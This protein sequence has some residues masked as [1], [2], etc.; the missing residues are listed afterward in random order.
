MLASRSGKS[1]DRVTVGTYNLLE[2]GLA[3]GAIPWVMVVPSALTNEASNFEEVR[4]F[5]TKEYVV[6]WHKNQAVGDYRRFRKL[7]GEHIPTDPVQAEQLLDGLRAEFILNPDSGLAEEDSVLVNGKKCTTLR[8]ILRKT[9]RAREN[10][11][12]RPKLAASEPQPSGSQ[13]AEFQSR[14]LAERIFT[15]IHLSNTEVFAW[16]KR[17]NRLFQVCTNGAG[18][19][20]EA[21]DETDELLRF[22]GRTKPN[23]PTPG[24]LSLPRGEG[25]D[26]LVVQ[27]Y[28]FHAANEACPRISYFNGDGEGSQGAAHTLSFGEAMQAA[29]YH[30]LLFE[31]PKGDGSG[32]G[33]FAKA[34]KLRVARTAGS[35]VSSDL[36]VDDSQPV[37]RVV[38]CGGWKPGAA[39]G[40]FDFHETHHPIPRTPHSSGSGAGSVGHGTYECEPVPLSD[41]KHCAVAAFEFLSDD[42]SDDEAEHGAGGRRRVVVLGCHLMTTSRDNPSKVYFP[43]SIR[44]QEIAAMRRIAAEFGVGPSDA[45]VVA[46]DFNTNVREGDGSVS[47]RFVLEGVIPFGGRE[48]DASGAP[49]VEFPTGYQA[50]RDVASALVW[51]RAGAPLVLRDAYEGL[52][53]RQVDDQDVVLGTSHNAARVE[54]IDFI[55]YDQDWLSPVSRSPL[56]AP[57][58]DPTPDRANPSDHIPVLVEFAVKRTL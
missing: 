44:A 15:H 7:F 10:P 48:S 20:A 54:T 17:A 32:I 39:L 58:P 6:N 46:G 28:D 52:N 55:W 34:S 2:Q 23:T 31:G 36:G 5:L 41:R 57:W 1:C 51:E 3:F 42:V 47:E 37:N 33:V 18:A 49:S 21:D 35:Q 45:V 13:E 9:L 56:A 11:S 14:A 30:A 16:S 4:K 53:R 26:I 12:K 8:G 40:A 43:G 19:G 38:S 25:P 27:E 22:Y 50:E 29:G 24:V